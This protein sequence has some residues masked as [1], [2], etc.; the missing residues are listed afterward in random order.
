MKAYLKYGIM[1][2]A[3]VVGVAAFVTGITFGIVHFKNSVGRGGFDS[4]VSNHIEEAISEITEDTGLVDLGQS[5]YMQDDSELSYISYRV[6]KGDMIG[7]IADEFGITQDTIISVNN[8]RSSRLIQI[9]QYLKIPSLP[10]IL[11]TVHSDGETIETIAEKYKVDADKCSSVNNI[12]LKEPLTAGK[13]LFVPYA[14]LDWIT[15]QEINGDL[16]KRPLKNRYYFTSMFGWRKNPFDASKRTYH[17]GI[18]M[19]CAKGTTV[20][21]ALPGKVVTAGW[22]DV[23]GNYVVI[24]HHSG[25]KSLYGHMDSITTKKGAF[26]DTNSRIGKVGNTGMSTGPHLHFAVYKNGRSVNPANLWN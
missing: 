4:Q 21:A 3:A 22:S 15:R 8:I 12:S 25:Y 10:G 2:G 13:S 20:Y 7:Y 23:Y 6:K 24:A 17:G 5:N 19:A 18:D 1:C 26:V 14:E 11:Y 16:F 9:G